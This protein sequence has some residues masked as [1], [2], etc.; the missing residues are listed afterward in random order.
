MLGVEKEDYE[1][2]RDKVYSQAAEIQKTTKAFK[3]VDEIKIF[4]HEK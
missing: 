3:P 4:Y 2:Y 1:S